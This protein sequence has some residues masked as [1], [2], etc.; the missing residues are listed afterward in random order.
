MARRSKGL[1]GRREGAGRKPGP[2]E[3][4]RR[5]RV[6]FTVTDRELEQLQA[7]A[8]ERELPLGTLAH[9]II[10]RAM[11]WRGRRG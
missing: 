2:P 1:G 5:N 11:R 3:L 7:L 8:G 4:V 10:A 6:T 9:R